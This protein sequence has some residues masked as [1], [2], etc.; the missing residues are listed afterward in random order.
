MTRKPD[1][2]MNRLL[3][4]CRGAVAEEIDAV[5]ADLDRRGLAAPVTGSDGVR[6]R[7]TGSARLY[8]WTLPAGT[9]G[10][11][12]DDAVSIDTESG[13]GFGFVVRFDGV[14]NS[15]RIATDASLGAHP[16]LGQLTFDPSWLL[17]ALDSRLAHIEQ[18]PDKF[19]VAT[20]LKLFGKTFPGVGER[21]PESSDPSELNDSQ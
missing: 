1:T 6:V 12:V 10:I 19:H 17:E 8:D 11:R 3:G 14:R 18:S 15:L 9:F 20:A 7:G 2:E 5:R 13:S 16:G 4:S 21:A